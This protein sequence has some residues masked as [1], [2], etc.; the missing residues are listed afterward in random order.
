MRGETGFDT[1]HHLQEQTEALRY[2]EERL[3]SITENAPDYIVQLDANGLITFMN[4]TAPGFTKEQALG[5]DF[6]A[7]VLHGYSFLFITEP[8][9]KVVYLYDVTVAAYTIRNSRIQSY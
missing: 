6:T 8:I 2:S 5:T 9:S 3:R 4:R 7:W 1:E